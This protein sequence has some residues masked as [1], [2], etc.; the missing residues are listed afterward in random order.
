MAAE[1]GKKIYICMLFYFLDDP[2]LNDFSVKS[3]MSHHVE[4]KNSYKLLKKIIL[5]LSSFEFLK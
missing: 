1:K 4:V 3:C 2:F 5:N